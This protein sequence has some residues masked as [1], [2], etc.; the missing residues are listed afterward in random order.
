MKKHN[1]RQP[2]V[3]ILEGNPLIILALERVVAEL[4]WQTTIVN[5]F[6]DL[7]G[8]VD[9]VLVPVSG[10]EDL[11]GPLQNWTKHP[12]PPRILLF[13]HDAVALQNAKSMSS[14]VA[15]IVPPSFSTDCIR[16]VIALVAEGHQVI[17]ATRCGTHQASESSDMRDVLP[18][19]LTA[20]EIEIL[21][22]VAKGESN[23]AIA[24]NFGISAHTVEAHVSSV[25]RKLN[26]SNRTQAALAFDGKATTILSGSSLE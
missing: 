19:L 5:F 20:R 4:D 11:V 26:V 3:A 16:S 9:L 8:E 2:L 15:A 12:D 18:S 22:E 1:A 14:K 21:R 6:S 13:P 7:P 24:K 25:M 17:P 23:K 10:R